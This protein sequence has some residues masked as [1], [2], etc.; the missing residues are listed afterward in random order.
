MLF[1]YSVKRSHIIKIF[2]S[3]AL[4]KSQM[5]GDSPILCHQHNPFQFTGKHWTNQ[6]NQD[7]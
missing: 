3:G 6:V 2:V 4:S 7:Y 1:N 5:S